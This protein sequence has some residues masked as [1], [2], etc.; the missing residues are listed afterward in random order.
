MNQDE[1]YT[2]GTQN[3]TVKDDQTKVWMKTRLN[4]EGT[5]DTVKGYEYHQTQQ[6]VADPSKGRSWNKHY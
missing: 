5:R 1:R 2:E 6:L 4:C 3:E